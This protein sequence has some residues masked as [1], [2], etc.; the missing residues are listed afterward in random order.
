MLLK[1]FPDNPNELHIRK[2]V[3]AL[4]NGEVI[5]V[6]T[7]TVYA[8]ACDIYNNKAVEKICRLKNVK[9]EKANFSFLC[10]DLSHIS[11][12]TKPFSTEIFRLM[13]NSLPGPFTFILNANSNVPHIFKSNKKT[14]GIRVPDNNIARMIVKEL[15]NPLMVSSVHD[16]NAIVGYTSDPSDI[17]SHYTEQVSLIIDGGY[18]D[19]Q[20]STVVDCT[21]E[22][23]VIIREGKG[24]LGIGNHD[25]L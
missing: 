9:P 3:A 18:S 24:E 21:D 4:K 25:L 23:P 11:D 2:A 19:M 13:K 22:T 14:I 12:F 7:D 1:I 16:E 6:P 17:E 10:Y 15:G 8:L 20:P 5:I